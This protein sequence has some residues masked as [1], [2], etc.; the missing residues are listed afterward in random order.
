MDKKKRKPDHPEYDARTLYVPEDFKLKVTPVSALFF[1]YH[2]N[3]VFL[4][5]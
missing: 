4:I 1:P 5:F 3:I 2:K